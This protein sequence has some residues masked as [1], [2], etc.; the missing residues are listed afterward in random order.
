[1]RLKNIISIAAAGVLLMTSCQDWLDVRPAG[2]LIPSKASEFEKLL[3]NSNTR[4]FIMQDNNRGSY[5]SMLA[6]NFTIGSVQQEYEFIPS[7]VNFDR[8]AAYIYYLPYD[9]PSSSYFGWTYQWRGLYYFNNVIDGISGLPDSEKNLSV[10][11]EAVAQAKAARAW[12]L[13]H[14]GLIYGPMYDPS[15]AANDGKTVPYRTSSDISSPNPDRATLA[16]LFENLKIDLDDAMAAPDVVAHPVRAN[17]ACVHA[18]RAQ[19]YMYQGDWV[20]M[21]TEANEAWTKSLA[22]NQNNPD[23]MLYN[24][25]DFELFEPSTPPTPKPGEDI[26]YYYTFRVKE[27]KQDA[28]WNQNYNKENLLFRNCPYRGAYSYLDE[29]YVNLFADNDMRKQLFIFNIA[30]FEKEVDGTTLSDGIVQVNVRDSRMS[31]GRTQGI[32]YPILLLMRAEAY[33][34]NNR[35][36]D[37]LADLNLLRKYRYENDG[38]TA[39]QW[40]LPGGDGMTQDQ[41]L[42]EILNERRR[43]QP[44]SSYER[45]IDLKRYYFDTGKP[46]QKSSVTHKVLGSAKTYTADV[47]SDKFRMVYNNATINYNPQWNLPLWSTNWDPKSAE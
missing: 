12:L 41:L 38:A 13:M 31:G 36:G 40:E 43:E 42:T 9:N 44:I 19:M 11:V 26:E 46:W 4:D 14:M 6:D 45:T 21:L 27:G 35:L 39:S 33:A 8:Y 34:R 37:A 20:N 22:N 30:G 18:I 47:N 15:G 16:E 24:Y 25:N 32:S 29:E 7:M 5:V 17:K 1:M 3:N 2:K 10:A 28:I 23:N